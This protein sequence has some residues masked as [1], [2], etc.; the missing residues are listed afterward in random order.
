MSEALKC[1]PQ[2]P[3]TPHLTDDVTWKRLWLGP[4][5]DCVWADVE[6]VSLNTKTISCVFDASFCLLPVFLP[7][8][9]SHL[10]YLFFDFRLI[11]IPKNQANKIKSSSNLK[12]AKTFP[13]KGKDTFLTIKIKWLLSKIKSLSSFCRGLLD[14]KYQNL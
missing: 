1:R 10:Q 3:I 14:L 11:I 13:V 9:A 7:S 4:Q 2:F 12:L 5:L 6:W 8:P